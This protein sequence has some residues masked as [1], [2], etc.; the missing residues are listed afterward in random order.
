[1][2]ASLAEEAEDLRILSPEEDIHLMEAEEIKTEAVKTDKAREKNIL[3][4][5]DE[6]NGERTISIPL[7]KIAKA[8]LVAFF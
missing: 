3:I 7:K 8:R 2:F 1:L 5:V 4:F 6:K